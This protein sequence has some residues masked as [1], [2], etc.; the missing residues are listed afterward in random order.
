MNWL[1]RLFSSSPSKQSHDAR[2]ESFRLIDDASFSTHSDI[3]DVLRFVATLH[4]TTPYDV[5]IHHGEI[6]AG[7]PSKAPVYGSRADGIWTPKTKSWRDLGID[8]DDMPEGTHAS[9]IG[10]MF[11][12][13]YLPFLIQ[14][15][16]IVE[17]NSPPE[18]KLNGLES[19][20]QSSPSHARIW[21][22]LTSSYA[23]FP[24]SFLVVTGSGTAA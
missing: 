8:I 7:P 16:S 12:S 20:A 3:L 19:Y 2:A 14:F 9:D 1:K 18:E 6:F 11:P 21:A 24:E 13:E 15:R 5:L 4:A 10:L 17:S 23:N 22:R